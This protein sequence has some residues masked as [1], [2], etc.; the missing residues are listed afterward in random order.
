MPEKNRPTDPRDSHAVLVDEIA[1]LRATNERLIKAL[2]RIDRTTTG[3]MSL[4]LIQDIARVEIFN[5]RGD[6]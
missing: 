3:S 6:Q 5:A 2:Q 1:R 4:L